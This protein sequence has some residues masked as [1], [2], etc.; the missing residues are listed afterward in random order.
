MCRGATTTSERHVHRRLEWLPDFRCL[1]ACPRLEAQ[2][3]GLD[4]PVAFQELPMLDGDGF[5][6][7]Q[8][9]PFLL[10]HEFAGAL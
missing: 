10:P 4:A 8:S 2:S 5:V 3:L 9:W 1:E 7:V 6:T